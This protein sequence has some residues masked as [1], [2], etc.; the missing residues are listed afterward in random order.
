[1]IIITVGRLA[2]QLSV[3]PDKNFNVAIFFGHHKCGKYISNFA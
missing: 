1:M 3:Q 2:G